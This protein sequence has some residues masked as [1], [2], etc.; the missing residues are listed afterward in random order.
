[1]GRRDRNPWPEAARLPIPAGACVAASP[2]M[3]ARLV[4]VS[5]AAA[6]LET[7]EIY[8]IIRRAHAGN[9]PAGV[10]G[11][12]V[13]LDGWFVQVLE[14]EAGP[15]AARLA[16]IRADPRHADLQI[17]QH[18]R[19]HARIFAG[20]P[21]ALRTRACLDGRLLEGFGYRAGFPVA[22]FPADVLLEFVVQACRRRC[23]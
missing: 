2:A 22:D 9:A 17:R 4:Y 6:G 19:V 1:M 21:M 7:G 13:F 12:L 3:L 11:A 15:L 18:E 8:E 5:R 23:R 20:Q 10:T 16:R 14:G